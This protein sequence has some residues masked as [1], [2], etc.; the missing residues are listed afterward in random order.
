M[1]HLIISP[2]DC[3]LDFSGPITNEHSDNTEV[4]KCNE[5]ESSRDKNQRRPDRKDPAVTA[6]ALKMFDLKSCN[7]EQDACRNQ[8]EGSEKQLDSDLQI[9]TAYAKPAR[10]KTI[11][12]VL[13]YLQ[14]KRHAVKGDG[15][16][17]YHTI[18]H[19]AGLIASSSTGD[20]VVSNHLRRLTLLT[21]LN[22]PAIQLECSL[23]DQ[24]W[25]AKQQHVLTTSEWSGDIELRLMAIGLKKDILVI[26]DSSVGNAFARKF[27]HQPPPAPKMKGGV[28]IPVSSDELCSKEQ[29]TQLQNCLIVVYNGS[30]H[31]DSTSCIA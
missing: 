13:E 12:S 15:S 28:F 29:L 26:T 4:N 1:P 22:Y 2:S 16:C 18:A 23:S 20:E 30:N 6:N 17:L 7:D 3:T 24:D 11:Q 19:Q 8:A 31:Y 9:V 14:L 21:M 10:Y 27:P 5:Q 25:Q